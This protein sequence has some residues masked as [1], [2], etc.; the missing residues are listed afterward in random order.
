[1]NEME[2]EMKQIAKKRGV[3]VVAAAVVTVMVAA[4]AAVA[5]WTT[6]GSGEGAAAVGDVSAVSVAQTNTVTGLYPGG[7]AQDIDLDITNSNEG[8]VTIAKVAVSVSGTNKAGCTASDFTVTDATIGVDLTP[9]DTAFSGATSGASIAMKNTG[10]N[11]DACKNAS[12]TL[13]F[14][15]S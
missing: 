15:A 12:V 13:A 1:M 5:F 2:I 9:G 6:T 14:S 10:S 7:P 11:Q 4:G 8:N 3:A